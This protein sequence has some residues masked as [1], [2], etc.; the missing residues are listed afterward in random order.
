MSI[1]M[2]PALQWL[3]WVAGTSW[4][5]GDEDHA[6]QDSAAWKTAAD[7]LKALIGQIDQAKQATMEAY[8]DGEAATAMGARFDELRTGDMSL[9]KLAEMLQTIS[10]ST[11]DMG[12]Q[13]Q[14]IK[15]TVVV[16]LGVLAL[17]IM[18]AW[19][20]PPTA[21]A[22]EAAA[23]SSTRSFLKVAEDIVQ[24]NIMRLAA[25]AGAKT[26]QRLF[27]K[28]ILSGQLVAPTAKGWGV[29]SARAIENAAMAMGIDGAVQGGQ[30]AD[31]KRRHFNGTQF[32]VSGLAA[33]AGVI[34]GREVARFM[35]EYSH[36][37]F[38]N[39]LDNLA[40]RT[41]RGAVIGGTAGVVSTVFGN[42]AV[43]A[44]TGDWSA[45]GSGPGWT[46]GAA[47]GAITGGARGLFAK[48]SPI[49][50]S[51]IRY[52]FWMHK[53]GQPRGGDSPN[54]APGSTGESNGGTG[55]TRGGEGST[56]GPDGSVR[57]P[58]GST[59]DQNS[60]T[61]G[62]YGSTR[63]QNSRNGST[64]GLYGSTGDQNSQ[65]GSMRGQD[66]STGDRNSSTQGQYGSTRGQ[67]N[68]TPLGGEIQG[69]LPGNRGET[70]IPLQNMQSAG[71]GSLHP[72]AGGFGDGGSAV[73]DRP[74]GEGVVGP[75]QQGRQGEQ[76]VVWYDDGP[77]TVWLD[78]ASVNTRPSG[79]SPVVTGSEFQADVSTVGSRGSED[80]VVV[81]GTTPGWQPPT[82][83]GSSI[84]APGWQPS[85][86]FVHG[87]SGLDGS[88][89]V[90]PGRVPISD[91]VSSVSSG[92]VNSN[93]SP[94]SSLHGSGGS[95]PIRVQPPTSILTGQGSGVLPPPQ[96]S[97]ANPGGGIT[98]T[99]GGTTNVVAGSG[100]ST[101]G[102]GGSTGSGNSSGGRSG[103][104]SQHGDDHHGDHHGPYG[105]IYKEI[106][107]FLGEGK[108]LRAK[109]RPRYLRGTEPLPGPFHPAD[110]PEWGEWL[111][112]GA[113]PA[114][115]EDE[116]NSG[117]N[118]PDSP[119]DGQGSNENGPAD[120]PGSNGNE[121]NS[122]GDG[123]GS[124]ENGP[125][126]QGDGPKAGAGPDA[127]GGNPDIPFTLGQQ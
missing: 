12:T 83:F 25:S 5:D 38:K 68:G 119:G 121:S 46:G 42:I 78:G 85:N 99:G 122:P 126:S 75:G 59:R 57:G 96:P 31:G 114:P 4:P 61:Q 62:L 51:D 7:E 102:S 84:D 24:N 26:E 90:P 55:S 3:A 8:S 79:E 91:G 63:D 64:Q 50:S 32:G 76:V 19:M 93:P 97:T 22:V 33:A 35:G 112:P 117:E 77:Q 123:Q 23:V 48:S 118:G 66:G 29:Y 10:D 95:G 53:S 18:W 71:N 103:G 43:G 20:F 70:W 69:G 16:S 28:R 30:M 54:R 44:V 89:P 9:E 109:A 88:S 73:V 98:N 108:D 56:R 125:D 81:N 74:G 67:T 27:W 58:E 111:P 80:G 6:W 113:Y 17:E 82:S 86:T 1:E 60:S 104:G 15:L 39:Q 127:G 110:A 92:P 45:F 37:L 36:K 13:I 21:P 34:P 72:S 2:P 40:G 87:G 101:H 105:D 65:N 115:D 94:V 116:S 106:S 120:E 47:R 107:P 100:N 11:F 52:P 124:N 49:T 14:G 41:F